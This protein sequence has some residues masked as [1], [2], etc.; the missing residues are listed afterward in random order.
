MA[1]RSFAGASSAGIALPMNLSELR[2][3]IPYSVAAPAA[4]ALG[5]AENGEWMVIEDAAEQSAWLTGVFASERI[6][7]T[8]WK[9]ARRILVDAGMS[10]SAVDVP[11]ARSL[12]DVE[13]RH[14]YRR[15]FKARRCGRLH[16]IPIWEKAKRKGRRGECIV[17]LDPGMA[18]G[19]GNHE[20]TRLV[21][22]R[23][24]DL[25]RKRR[26]SREPGSLVDAGCGSGI[27][28]L[29][30]ASLGFRPVTAFDND[31]EAVRI[32]RENAK[33]NGRSKRIRFSVADLPQG[34]S[35]GKADVV[36]ANIQA[37]VLMH[38]ARELVA[39]VKPGGS[40]VL[41]GILATEISVVER[42]FLRVCIGLKAHSRR[43]GI[44]RDLLVRVPTEDGSRRKLRKRGP[45]VSGP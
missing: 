22:R 10:I 23:L 7:M 16:W 35:G 36:L 27:L 29:S 44:W 6:G 9:R 19:T 3:E 28:A 24:V 32:S 17:W 41:S 15:H 42:A 4:D 39:A 21:A 13:W 33:L 11:S 38:H 5:E 30:A 2:F 37:D 40:L 45:A 12:P 1:R 18:F 43:L 14:S 31:A 26:G 34:L 20:S 25:D 8:S